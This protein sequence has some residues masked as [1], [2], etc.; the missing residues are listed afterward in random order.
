MEAARTSET[1]V[2]FYQTTRRYN[3]EDSHLRSHRRENL[4]SY[5]LALDWRQLTEWCE[6][7]TTW[8]DLS[9]LL[10]KHS[11][12]V[13]LLIQSSCIELQL[14]INILIWVVW[15]FDHSVYGPFKE[16]R[17]LANIMEIYQIWDYHGGEGVHGGLMGSDVVW[18]CRWKPTFQWNI[19]PTSSELRNPKIT[20]S[21]LEI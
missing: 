20:M 12:V 21:I 17:L 19:L 3:P 16:K 1:L 2:N 10:Y 9:G 5:I 13:C 11:D 7:V 14:S 8:R 15:L 6:K 18:N 4:K